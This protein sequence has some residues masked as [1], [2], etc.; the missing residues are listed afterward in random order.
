MFNRH[1][2]ARRSVARFSAA[3]LIEL[4]DLVQGGRRNGVTGAGGHEEGCHKAAKRNDSFHTW[5]SVSS[6]YEVKRFIIEMKRLF[7]FL[8]LVK[9]DKN[10]ARDPIFKCQ[11]R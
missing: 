5:F 11:I 7:S 8:Q 2:V 3:L 4:H 10:L 6:G 9:F 1:G